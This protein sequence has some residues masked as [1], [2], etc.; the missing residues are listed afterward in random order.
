MQQNVPQ[1]NAISAVINFADDVDS[2][3]ARRF[4]NTAMEIGIIKSHDCRSYND[5]YGT[6]VWYI[7]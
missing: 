7:P 4:L 6:P 3:R 2:E 1:P 5:E